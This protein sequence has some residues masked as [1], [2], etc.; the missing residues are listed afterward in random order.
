M[1][2]I[3]VRKMAFEIPA[4]DDFDPKWLVNNIVLSYSATGVSLYVAYLE[5]FLVKSLRRVLDQIRDDELREN[6][7]RFCR[8]E[9]QH[10]MQHERFNEAILQCGYPGLRER[11]D[12]LKADF[13]GYLES[14]GDKWCVGFVEGFEAYTTQ[15]ALRA[16]TSGAFEHPC[17]DPQFGA[18]FKWHMT[19]EIEHRNVAF[20]IYQ[21]LYGDWPFR[22]KMCWI[23]QTHIWRFILDCMKIMSPVDV[24]RFD[25]SYKVTAVHRALAVGAV[26]PM[27][28]KTYTPWYDPHRYQVPDTIAQISAELT[29]AAESAS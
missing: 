26:A 27:F 21:H 24:A 5:P 6:V 3:P 25:D 20:D 16:L 11:F 19:E 2:P 14:R 13:D 8:Q 10:Y 29:A 17:T 1:H 28:M 9:A 22:A 23:A 18:L 15:S 7:D 12:R 4:A